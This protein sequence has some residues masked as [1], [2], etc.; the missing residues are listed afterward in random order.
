MEPDAKSTGPG[1]RWRVGDLARATGLTVRTLHHYE[2]IGLLER[3]ART[4]SGHRLYTEASIRR[5]YRIRVLRNLGVPLGG[6]R[7]IID[8]GQSLASVLHEHLAR[9]EEQVEALT[10]LRDGLRGMCR[11]SGPDEANAANLLRTIE[12]MSRLERHVE[13]RRARA[14]PAGSIERQWQALGTELRACLDAGDDPS[15]VRVRALAERARALIHDFSAGDAAIVDALAHLRTA[16]PPIELAG[17][18][19]PLMAYL[20]RALRALDTEETGHAE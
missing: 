17:W 6:I 10:R 8:D 18:D 7:R 13:T 4:E 15:S 3:P 1:T 12:A 19:P 11:R 9:V 16:A 20:D 5:L 2:A 14:R